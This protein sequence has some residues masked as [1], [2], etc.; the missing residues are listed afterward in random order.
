MCG[1]GCGACEHGLMGRE[2]P[3]VSVSRAF[4]GVY[5]VEGR[6]V[7]NNVIGALVIKRNFARVF[8]SV[9]GLGRRRSEGVL[10]I[11]MSART[12]GAR[13][14]LMPLCWGFCRRVYVLFVPKSEWRWISRASFLFVGGECRCCAREDARG[15]VVRHRREEAF[16]EGVS[17][18]P[19]GWV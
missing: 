18:C 5:G 13:A 14:H 19:A 7:L 10:S 1:E 16:G 8:P 15:A 12:S 4:S 6:G 3:P 17:G 9:P 2:H 11:R